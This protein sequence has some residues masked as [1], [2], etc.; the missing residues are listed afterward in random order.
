MTAPKPF[1]ILALPRSRTYWLSRFLS[2]NQ[3]FCTHDLAIDCASIIEFEAK[4]TQ[5]RGTVETGAAFAWPL[6]ARQAR[7]IV[8]RRSVGPVQASLK[9]LGLEIP[10]KE[11]QTRARDLD[12]CSERTGIMTIRYDGLKN[13]AVCAWLFETCLGIVFDR[14]WW[15]AMSQTNIQ[16][17]LAARV[18]KLHMNHRRIEGLKAEVRQAIHG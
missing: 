3:E 8:V 4:L 15:L 11:I 1:V 17:D 16:L 5:R 10:L 2:Y 12:N 18:K 13:E 7:V 6:L 9:K 14:G